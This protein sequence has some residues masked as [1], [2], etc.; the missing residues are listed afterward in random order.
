MRTHDRVRRVDHRTAY[1]RCHLPTD[2]EFQRRFPHQLSG[3]QQQRLAIA[4]HS[5]TAHRVVV[6]DEPTTGLDVVTQSRIL[7]ELDRLR[8]DTRTAMIYVSHDLAVVGGLADRIAVMYGGWIVEEGPADQILRAPSHPYT[9]GLVASIPDH[10]VP[11]RLNGIPGVAVGIDER[12]PGCPFA[13]RCPQR[14][15]Q[16][17]ERDAAS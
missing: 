12:P 6:L 1:G 5:S 8:N 13:P 17:D 2:A 14:T 15:D 16:A 7:A 4:S 9:R 3:G 10:L 11:R